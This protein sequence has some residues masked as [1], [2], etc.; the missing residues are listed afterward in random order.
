MTEYHGLIQIKP[1]DKIR[2]V[3]DKINQATLNGRR[4]EAHP[5]CKR[6]TRRDP[7]KLLFNDTHGSPS[8]RRQV[9][10]RRKNLV[11]Q[12]IDASF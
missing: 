3:V 11:S 5:Y 12:V 1:V 9:E 6:F 2:G 10:R 7:R 8:E 4:L